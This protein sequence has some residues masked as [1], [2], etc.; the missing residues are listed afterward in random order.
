MHSQRGSLILQF[1]KDSKMDKKKYTNPLKPYLETKSWFLILLMLYRQKIFLVLCVKGT[2]I[3]D[4]SFTIP[5]PP[6]KKL[7]YLVFPNLS[8]SPSRSISL[9]LSP[10]PSS[11]LQKGFVNMTLH[12][13]IFTFMEN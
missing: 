6:L 12:L 13:V 10:S 7:M 9:S 1:N 5:P 11:S 3:T 2:F 4:L 8:L